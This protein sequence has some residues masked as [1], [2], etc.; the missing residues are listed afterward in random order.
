[1]RRE[2]G[3]NVCVWTG[4]CNRENSMSNKRSERNNDLHSGMLDQSLI[5]DIYSRQIEDEQFIHRCLTQSLSRLSDH[6]ST[7]ECVRGEQ[8]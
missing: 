7:C 2:R 8:T 4:G 1:M 5:L 6:L 3:I